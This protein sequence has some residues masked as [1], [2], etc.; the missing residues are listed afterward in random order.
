[1]ANVSCQIRARIVANPG[2]P[3]TDEEL[4]R[5]RNQNVTVDLSRE[6]SKVTSQTLLQRLFL[7]FQY[8]FYHV[9]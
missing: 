8:Y 1:M 6:R 3:K 2:Q 5:I 7:S 4:V 9:N